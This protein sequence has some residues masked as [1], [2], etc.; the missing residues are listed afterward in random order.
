MQVM[1]VSKPL[2]WL[3][4]IWHVRLLWVMWNELNDKDPITYSDCNSRVVGK[5]GVKMAIYVTHSDLKTPCVTDYTF[6]NTITYL[7]HIC[8]CYTWSVKLKYW[9][10]AINCKMLWFHK[11]CHGGCHLEI[12]KWSVYKSNLLLWSLNN[13]LEWILIV[14]R[15]G[16]RTHLF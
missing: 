13:V 12:R 7:Q 14:C 4:H 3:A 2:T 16:H 10:V 9:F 5:V 6:C 1:Q 8:A 11:P 15:T